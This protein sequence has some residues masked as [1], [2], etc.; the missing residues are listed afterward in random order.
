MYIYAFIHREILW[1]IDSCYIYLWV[2]PPVLY[3]KHPRPCNSTSTP[4]NNNKK[5]GCTHLPRYIYHPNKTE[6]T[7]LCS[8]LI[9]PALFFDLICF[10]MCTLCSRL[11]YSTLTL[12]IVQIVCLTD[13]Y[14]SSS[15]RWAIVFKCDKAFGY[16]TKE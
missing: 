10:Y 7:Q 13:V 16:V 3:T 4:H 9:S 6:I 5:F 15:S 2:V 1:L 12:F 8:P 14:P 11:Y